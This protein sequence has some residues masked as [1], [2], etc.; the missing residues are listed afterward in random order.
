MFQK[1]IRRTRKD[2]LKED[3]I[4]GLD[5]YLRARTTTLET[6]RSRGACDG[7]FPI[8]P[9]DNGTTEIGY[10]RKAYSV[11]DFLRQTLDINGDFNLEDA[12]INYDTVLS[13]L[14]YA[15]EYIECKHYKDEYEK[16]DWENTVMAFTKAKEILEN[17]PDA[18]IFY[19][20]W[21]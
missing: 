2:R 12:E 17:D 7:L 15:E 8:A 14:S 16:Y 21:Y 11:S 1:T 6:K 4:M 19:M 5:Q 18:Q 10:W 20:E 13:I 9:S 3:N